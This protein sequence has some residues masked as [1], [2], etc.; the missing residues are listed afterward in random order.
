[1]TPPPLQDTLAE[2]KELNTFFISAEEIIKSGGSVDMTTMDQRIGVV[3]QAVQDAEPEQQQHFLP[4]L[5]VLLN[6]LNSC[7]L[8]IRALHDD[9][10]ADIH[11]G[12]GHDDT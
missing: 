9:S 11:E 8:A 3:C 4:E 10:G 12:Q 6:Q 2:L 7:E 1:M 5:T